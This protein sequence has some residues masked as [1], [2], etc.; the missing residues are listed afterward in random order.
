MNEFLC[1]IVDDEPALRTYL[2]VLLQGRGIRSLEA[3]NAVDA[4]RILR[5]LDGKIDLLISDIQ[6]PGDMDGVDLAYSVNS[7]S[8]VSV[9]LISS[10]ITEAP[11][12]FPFI[13]KP[14]RSDSILTL[15][16]KTLN[17]ILVRGAG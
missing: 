17:G 4:L 10:D 11:P 3:G 1:L 12:G 7:F 14:F 2:Q 16:D 5:K 6:M 9:I 13:P 15:V 8:S